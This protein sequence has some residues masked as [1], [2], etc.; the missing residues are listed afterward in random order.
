[1]EVTGKMRGPLIVALCAVALASVQHALAADDVVVTKTPPL[2]VS[3]AY[4][5]S[6]FYAGGHL[7]YAWGSSKWTASS[8]GAPNV[9][10]SFNLAQPIDTFSETGSFFA[11]LQAGY[12]Y[13]LPNRLLVGAEID[14]IVPELSESRR[15]LHRRH[16]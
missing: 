10:G 9:S 6:G 11:G 14:A 2:R 5:W 3:S 12:N 4:D 15:H 8:P 13:M 16:V 1:M 7:G